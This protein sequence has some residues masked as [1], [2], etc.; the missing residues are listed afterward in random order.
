VKNYG[1]LLHGRCAFEQ[2]DDTND[3]G[4]TVG[5]AH[6]VKGDT[7]HQPQLENGSWQLVCMV[8]RK[9]QECRV[10]QECGCFSAQLLFHRTSILAA[11]C[12]EV[13][14]VRNDEQ[15]TWNGGLCKNDKLALVNLLTTS[16]ERSGCHVPDE[17]YDAMESVEPAS[18]RLAAL[19][20]RHGHE[21]QQRFQELE[22]I[23]AAMDAT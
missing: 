15:L 18:A 4:M 20:K 17:F 6:C 22:Q 7:Y 11:I 14:T 9:G 16:I 21:A 12:Q 13:L 5:T 3:G 10:G 23:V 2:V 19:F 1:S 8:R